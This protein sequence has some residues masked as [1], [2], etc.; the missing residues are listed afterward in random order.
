MR[1]FC[2][3]IF[4][5]TFVGSNYAS[6]AK[7]LSNRL[8]HKIS[9][10]ELTTFLAPVARRTLERHS[11][12]EQVI[13]RSK[14]TESSSSTA[15]EEEVDV[16]PWATRSNKGS[17]R[18][19]RSRFRQHVNPLAR[20]FQIPT[21]LAE[22][23]PM[24]AF[25]TPSLPLHIDIGCGK[26][27]FLLDLA[28][29]PPT[30]EKKNYL[31]LEIRPS[32]VEFAQDRAVRLDLSERLQYIGCNANV[33]LDRLLSAYTEVGGGYLDL[34]SIQFPDP[35]FK[36][37]HKKRRVVTPDL[38]QTLAKFIPVGKELFIQSDIKDVFDMMRTEIRE[39]DM[40]FED[41]LENFDET[42]DVNPIGVPTEREVSVLKQDLPVY[43]TVF[44]RTDRPFE[45]DSV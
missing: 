23:W 44:K 35:L 33:D 10:K 32:V 45:E 5:A 29:A 7:H 17:S 18:Q 8:L 24:N 21:E 37:Q 12:C 22:N 30:E 39:F 31:G 11:Q 9:S 20:K 42:L 14:S 36:K 27:G 40:Y 2:S 38:V 15:S 1:I 13:C 4:L 6:H 34:V 3:S 19:N 43:R 16:S 26:G 28:T 41:T 25:E